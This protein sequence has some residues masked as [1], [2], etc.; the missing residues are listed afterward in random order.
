MSIVPILAAEEQRRKH[1]RQRF[2]QGDETVFHIQSGELGVGYLKESWTEEALLDLPEGQEHNYLERKAGEL[3][4]NQHE[5]KKELAKTLS[6]FANSGGGH[7]I[8]GQRNDGTFDGVSPI[9]Q[10][11]ASSRS[12]RVRCREWLEQVIPNLVQY[13]LASFRVHE[14][15]KTGQDST[16]PADK[17]VIVID[18]GDSRLAP[19]QAVFPPDA[20]NYYY[21]AGGRS[22]IAPHHYLELLRSRLV[23]AIVEPQVSAVAI[24]GATHINPSRCCA[25]LEVTFELTNTSRIAC[26]E[27]QMLY[28]FISSNASFIPT[29]E[30][31]PSYPK[32]D[33]VS[34]GGK[35]IL[36]TMS[37]QARIHVPVKW[38]LGVAIE[39][40][41]KEMLPCL[42][43]ACSVITE[44][45]IGEEKVFQLEN[46]ISAD[47][48]ITILR[49][50]LDANGIRYSWGCN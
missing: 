36:P 34:L 24:V 1:S 48:M 44:N 29:G 21:R 37:F 7:V 8:L 2:T 4:G 40:Q 46:I 3:F 50:F 11:S 12:S 16:I 33:N 45:H 31:L 32:A 17:E 28:K 10:G 5:L 38:Q 39:P 22:V 23:A 19:H 25:V 18:I 27:W 14:V 47:R 9:Y 20:P 42:S 30:E 6:A 41:I 26:Y 43:I 35:T 49:E 15:Q 13:P